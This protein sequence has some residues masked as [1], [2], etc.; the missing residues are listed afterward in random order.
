MKL[1]DFQEVGAAWLRSHMPRRYLAD[2][3]GLGKTV[4]AAAAARYDG[5]Q[6]ALVIS[7]PSAMANWEAE[8]RT[9]GP[10]APLDVVSWGDRKL[11]AG[12]LDGSR[13]PLVIVDEAHRA[14]NPRAIRTLAALNVARAATRSWLLS[15]T[16]MPN[17]PGELWAP[18]RALW[19]WVPEQLGI[20][21]YEQWMQS[22]TVRAP[23]RH[24][25]RVVGVRN[26]S[27]LLPF[28]R[29]VFLRRSEEDVAADLPPLRVDVSLLP[30]AGFEEALRDA[31]V[32]LEALRRAILAEDTEDGSLARLRRFLGLWK[33]PLIA[34]VVAEELAAGEYG[35][36]VIM[37]HHHAVLDALAAPLRKFGL[38]ELRGGASPAQR[39]EAEQRFTRGEA[40]VFL[41][42]QQAAGEAINLQVASEIILAEPDWSPDS[43]YQAIKRVHRMFGPGRPVRARV[44]AAADTADEAVLRVE[45]RKLTDKGK[46]GL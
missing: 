20:R 6:R 19:P 41:G 44:F 33:A 32:P 36:I 8:W 5:V 31:G 28:L 43:N 29:Q 35:Q 39:R 34:G 13:Y 18:L 22:F 25:L 23:G 38:V 26:E 46:F 16:P 2:R 1:Y 3:C 11:L 24:G 40:R 21:S 42:Q 7:P 10:D 9:W 37:A 30:A 17:H 27:R 45:A 15:A 14:K 12:E 4:Q